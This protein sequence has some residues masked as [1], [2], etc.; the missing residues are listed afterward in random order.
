M[1]STPK[2]EPFLQDLPGRYNPSAPRHILEC[3]RIVPEDQLDTLYAPELGERYEMGHLVVLPGTVHLV[4][5]PSIASSNDPYIPTV[6]QPTVYHREMR[7]LPRRSG[8][9]EKRGAPNA[10]NLSTLMSSMNHPQHTRPLYHSIDLPDVG[11]DVP[12]FPPRDSRFGAQWY[13]SQ[14]AGTRR[15]MPDAK[16][17]DPTIQ[18]NSNALGLFT[19]TLQLHPIIQHAL[20]SPLAAD[21]QDSTDPG[22]Q[23]QIW[24]SATDCRVR[25]LLII[26]LG[27]GVLMD[28]EPSSRD[29]DFVRV[30]DVLRALKNKTMRASRDAWNG[31][32]AGMLVRGYY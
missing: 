1:L 29:G 2:T 13:P 16:I 25:R 27:T 4:M 9:R 5:D 20:S 7:S 17:L 23:E 10:G 15:W 21:L 28:V 24:D 18:T 22:M 12:I 32:K 30:G 3:A 19:E 11:E 14:A 6:P 31:T 8:N 26:L